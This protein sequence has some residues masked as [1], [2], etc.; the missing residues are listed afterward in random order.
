MGSPRWSS[1]QQQIVFDCNIEGTS[2]IY[3]V[4]AEGGKPQVVPDT[5]FAQVPSWSRDG[6]WIYY[7]SNRTGRFEV[8]R[9]PAKG[10]APMQVTKYGGYVAYEAWDG[11]SLYYAKSDDVTSSME[12]VS[13]FKWCCGRDQS[14]RTSGLPRVGGDGDRTLVYS[15]A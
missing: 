11:Q 2:G 9:V 1:D 15:G 4:G 7:A 14:T 13:G 6:K 3:T 8:W 10:G 12:Y 5:G